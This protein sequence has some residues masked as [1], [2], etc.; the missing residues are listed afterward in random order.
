MTENEMIQKATK[1]FTGWCER[2]GLRVQQPNS[3]LSEAQGYSVIL[4]NVRGE[5]A[6]Y[7]YDPLHN[8]MRPWLLWGKETTPDGRRVH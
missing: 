4:R 6:R 1:H 5:L 8:R 2:N 7:H 3:A